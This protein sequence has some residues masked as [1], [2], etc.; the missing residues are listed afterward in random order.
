MTAT[1]SKAEEEQ[2]KQTNQA[3]FQD[4]DNAVS[5]IIT[6]WTTISVSA[7][8]KFASENLAQDREKRNSSQFV[9]VCEDEFGAMRAF[10]Q[11]KIEVQAV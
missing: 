4:L 6:S 5:L 10:V 1:F 3:R 11:E 7:E 8:A 9:P 2:P